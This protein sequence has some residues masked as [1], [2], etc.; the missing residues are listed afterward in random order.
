LKLSDDIPPA[1]RPQGSNTCQTRR[2]IPTAMCIG[3]Q[4]HI[5]INQTSERT[6]PSRICLNPQSQGRALPGSQ[7]NTA[8]PSA[9]PA[10][11][12]RAPIGPNT[13][14]I[15]PGRHSS[16]PRARAEPDP[17]A[18]TAKPEANT[19]KL[20]TNAVNCEVSATPVIVVLVATHL[21]MQNGAS[22]R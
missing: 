14:T 13:R 18:N 1:S 4:S 6:H 17:E 20:R 8:K 2:H 16:K 9:N 5:G 3:T 15:R 7:V 21:W 12:G 22:C 10:K 19:F 11:R